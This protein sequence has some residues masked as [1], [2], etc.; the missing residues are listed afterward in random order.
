M[1]D[2]EC[3]FCGEEAEM[4]AEQ[5]LVPAG[6]VID[7]ALKNRGCNCVA[8]LVTRNYDPETGARVGY[9]EATMAHTETCPLFQDDPFR[10][11]PSSGFYMAVGSSPDAVA[12]HPEFNPR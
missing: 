12:E 5:A 4:A 1:S 10:P 9:I 3:I 6:G 2:D 8:H 11:V 7:T